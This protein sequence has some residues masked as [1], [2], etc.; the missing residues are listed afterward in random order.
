MMDSLEPMYLDLSGLRC[1]MPVLK[2]KQQLKKIA[3]FVQLDILTDHPD[4]VGDIQLF[5]R[6]NDYQCVEQ[7]IQRD[8]YLVSIKA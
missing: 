2:I 8:Q 3:V 7:K 4:V 5:C 1:P 6:K